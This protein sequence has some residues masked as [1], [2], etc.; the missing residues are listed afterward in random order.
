MKKL[1]HNLNVNADKTEYV[2][3]KKETSLLWN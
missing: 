1:I 2:L 3:I